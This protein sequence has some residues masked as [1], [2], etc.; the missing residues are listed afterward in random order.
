MMETNNNQEYLASLDQTPSDVLVN[1]ILINLPLYDIESVCQY[2]NKLSNI[3]A[4]DNTWKT[5]SR[6]KY[7]DKL[8]NKSEDDSWKDFYFQNSI[9]LIPLTWNGDIQG[10][11]YADHSN[12]W[13]FNYIIQSI[14]SLIGNN[15]NFALVLLS[16]NNNFQLKILAVLWNKNGKYFG[17]LD[18]NVQGIKEAVLITDQNNINKLVGVLSNTGSVDNADIYEIVRNEMMS[19]NGNPSIY[20]IYNKTKGSLYI[21]DRS[22]VYDKYLRGRDLLLFSRDGLINIHLSLNQ[23]QELPDNISM[24]DLQDVIIDDL[25]NIGH[26]RL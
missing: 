1:H 11:V 16:D 6:L 10:M 19:I 25:I 14:R 20:G 15:T 7:S 18:D 22:Y 24:S 21:V 5:L 23:A 13:N 17:Y 9:D 26:L 3:C 4:D 12:G 8:N 2:S